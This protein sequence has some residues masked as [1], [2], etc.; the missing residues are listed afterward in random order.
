MPH[1]SE[2]PSNVGHLKYK[3]LHSIFLNLTGSRA[4]PQTEGIAEP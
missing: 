4:Q 2:I 1:L 3:R